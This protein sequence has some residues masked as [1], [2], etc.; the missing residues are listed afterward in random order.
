MYQ[1]IWCEYFL[2]VSFFIEEN[3]EKEDKK[4]MKVTLNTKRPQISI[5]VTFVVLYLIIFLLTKVATSLHIIEF[6]FLSLASGFAP[7]YYFRNTFI[8]QD[9]VGWLLHAAVLGVIF[10]PFLF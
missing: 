5:V 4:I 6:A 1:N 10:I 2:E 7:A 3:F 9:L 8:C